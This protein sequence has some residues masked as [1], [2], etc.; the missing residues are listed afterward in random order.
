ML[1]SILSSTPTLIDNLTLQVSQVLTLQLFS[2]LHAFGEE[3][4][5]SLFC[6]GDLPE[7]VLLESVLVGEKGE[8]QF[9]VFAGDAVL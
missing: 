2:I 7:D 9:G 4:D 6:E 3:G 5:L 8:E 1:S